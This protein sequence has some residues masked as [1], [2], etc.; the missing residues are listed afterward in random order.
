MNSAVL[1][2]GQ[3]TIAKVIPLEADGITENTNAVV[4]SASWS[5][6]DSAVLEQTVNSD[7]T[8]T[9]KAVAPGTAT[10]VA[11]TVVTDADGTV[12]TLSASA[13]VTVSAPPARTASIGIDFST[14][15]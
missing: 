2:V 13:T 8:A 3:S 1:I 4:T 7:L 11:S 10:V 6:S 14:P 15:A 12:S 9:Y 5:V